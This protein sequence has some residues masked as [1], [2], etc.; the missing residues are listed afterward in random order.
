MTTL[1]SKLFW[2]AIIVPAQVPP[3]SSEST[4][5]ATGT[6]AATTMNMA[7]DCFSYNKAGPPT[8]PFLEFSGDW[9]YDSAMS[10]AFDTLEAAVWRH[11]SAARLDSGCL[12]EHTLK[13][14][15]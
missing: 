1:E 6:T 5:P 4:S 13:C 9:A 11:G 7:H 14:V 15:F 10:T 2:D 12:K 8:V 3:E